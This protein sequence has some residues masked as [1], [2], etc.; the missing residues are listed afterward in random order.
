[1]E[2]FRLL[3]HEMHDYEIGVLREKEFNLLHGMDGCYCMNIGSIRG[4]EIPTSIGK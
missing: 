1:M 4:D 2:G 3:V